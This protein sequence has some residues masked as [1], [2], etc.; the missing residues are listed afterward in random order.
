M[1]REMSEGWR[2]FVEPE[3]WSWRCAIRHYLPVRGYP[4]EYSWC[5]L[6]DAPARVMFQSVMTAAQVREVLRN[7][8]S[9]V[10]PRQ[11]VVNIAPSRVTVAGRKLAMLIPRCE[12]PSKTQGGAVAVCCH[13]DA[14]DRMG[15]NS[16]E[17]R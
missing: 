7:G 2:T 16:R 9:A 17:F 6:F 1:M 10:F 8:L 3:T 4:L 11:S 5:G 15:E 14:G 12:E 13:D